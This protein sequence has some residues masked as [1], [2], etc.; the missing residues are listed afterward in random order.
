[1]GETAAWTSVI[2]APAWFGLVVAFWLRRPPPS[3]PGLKG[4]F[5]RLPWSLG[6][7]AASAVTICLIAPD[8][9]LADRDDDSLFTLKPWAQALVAALAFGLAALGALLAFEAALLFGR[10]GRSLRGRLRAL[11]ANLI[12]LPLAFAVAYNLSPQVFYGLYRAIIPGLPDQWVARPLFDLEPLARAAALF[13]D[14]SLSDL[15]T[16]VTF[17]S[18]LLLTLLLHACRP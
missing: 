11:A 16:G 9:V 4:V 2:L 6:L 3:R 5:R 7:A 15:A 8:A 12:A 10:K 1:M 17:W 14:S 13:P 18:Y